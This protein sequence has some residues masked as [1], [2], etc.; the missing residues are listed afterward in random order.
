MVRGWGLEILFI[1]LAIGFAI[2]G[3]DVPGSMTLGYRLTDRDPVGLRIVTWNVGGDSGRNGRP[4]NNQWLPHIARVLKDLNPDI[5]LLQ[6]VANEPQSKRLRHMLGAGWHVSVTPGG[7]RRL[8]VLWQRGRLHTRQVRN[9]GRTALLSTYLS[10]GRPPVFAMNVHAD[11]YSAKRRNAIIGFATDVL[12]ADR[13]DHVKVLAGDLNLDID[14][15]KRSDLFTDDDDLD[16]QSYNYI[17][18]RLSDVTLNT[19]STAEPDRRLDYIFVKLDGL[20]VTRSGPWKGK[21][22]ADMDHDP[23]VADLRFTKP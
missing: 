19:G 22:L 7:G 12:M 15:D 17:A 14:P 1:V 10:V 5:V 18:Q 4:L 6:E 23:V 2:V 11:A 9:E 8:A 3:Y 20:D 13:T 21:R 16:V